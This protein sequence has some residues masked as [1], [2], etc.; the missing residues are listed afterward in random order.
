MPST[1]S[2]RTSKGRSQART[3]HSAHSPECFKAAGRRAV[4]L[5]LPKYSTLGTYRPSPLRQVIK[6]PVVNP[7][8]IKRRQVL[9]AQSSP[10]PS[11][12]TPTQQSPENPSVVETAVDGPPSDPVLECS[13]KSTGDGHSEAARKSHHGKENAKPKRSAHASRSGGKPRSGPAMLVYSRALYAVPKGQDAKQPYDPPPQNYRTSYRRTIRAGFLQSG[14]SNSTVTQRLGTRPLGNSLHRDLVASIKRKWTP[15]TGEEPPKKR[16]RLCVG[17]G[18]PSTLSP[19]PQ[20]LQNWKYVPSRS[21][22]ILRIPSWGSASRVRTAADVL[23]L[24]RLTLLRELP[25]KGMPGWKKSRLTT[26]DFLGPIHNLCWHFESMELECNTE[27]DVADADD[28]QT[29]VVVPPEG[30]QQSRDLTDAE[31]LE[32]PQLTGGRVADSNEEDDNHAC[33]PPHPCVDL[34]EVPEA[35]ELGIAAM[36]GAGDDSTAESEDSVKAAVVTFVEPYRPF[37]VAPWQDSL[38]LGPATNKVQE[39]LLSAPTVPWFESLL[40]RVDDSENDDAIDSYPAANLLQ[41]C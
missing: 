25:W 12:T 39:P 16:R 5:K 37:T 1:K 19:R 33:A 6:Q 34:P 28:V 24:Q 10:P 18:T 14:K 35:I 36:N 2:S 7:P 9:S 8:S 3:A 11:T 4:L 20:L 29:R 22:R 31:G 17:N 38:L 40:F 27:D 30:R 21:L 32:A 13:T 15:T 26:A 41:D 23:R